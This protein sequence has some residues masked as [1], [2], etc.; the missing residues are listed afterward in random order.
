LPWPTADAACSSSI[1][2]GRA[3][4][5]IRRIPRAIAPEVTITT[6]SP[7]WWRSATAA[8]IGSMTSV[9]TSPVGSAT[10]LDPSFTT[11]DAMG[12]GA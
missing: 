12:R 1:V 5:S 11:S 8:Q 4:R 6:W 2:A 9:R 7:A 3:A 10:M